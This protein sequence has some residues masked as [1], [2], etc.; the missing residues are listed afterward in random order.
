MT[1]DLHRRAEEL[2]TQAIHTQTGFT[3]R[4]FNTDVTQEEFDSELERLNV[5][6]VLENQALQQENRQLSVLLK[7]YEGTL[8]TV[9]GKFR[10]HAYATQ[11]HHLDLVRHYESILLALP[12]STTDSPDSPTGATIDPL[13]LS[14]SLA[15]LASLIRK[16]L[17]SIQGED[18]DDTTSPLIF[19]SSSSS[20]Q[21]SSSDPQSQSSP[22]DALSS[23]SAAFLPPPLVARP[24]PRDESSGGYIGRSATTAPHHIPTTSTSSLVSSPPKPGAI[25]LPREEAQEIKRKEQGLGPVDEALEREIELEQQDSGQSQYPLS[26]SPLSSTRSPPPQTHSPYPPQAPA[27]PSEPSFQ[28]YSSQNHGSYAP[29]DLDMDENA[30]LSANAAPLSGFPMQQQQEFYPSQDNPV[31][32]FMRQDPYGGGR[33]GMLPRHSSVTSQQSEAD[34]GRRAGAV[35]RGVTRKVKLTKGNFIANYA[36]PPAIV[37]SQ[38][39]KYKDGS[40]RSGHPEEFTHLRYTAATVDPNYFVPSSGW[41]LRQTLW[42]RETE[43]L[44]AITSYNEDKNL[45][46]RTLHSVMT[47]VRLPVDF[48]LGAILT[49]PVSQVRDIVKSKSKFW[50]RGTEEGKGGWEKIVVVLVADGIDPCAKDTLDLLA[51]V[52]VYQDNIMKKAIDGKDT[53]AHIFEYTTQLS[54]DTTPSLIVPMAN[55]EKH[56]MVP[57]QFVFCLKQKNAK[58]INS[59]RWVFNAFAS[60]LNPEVCILIDAGTKPGKLSLYELWNTFYNNKNCGG[61]CG[62]IY[63]MLEGGKKLLNPLV[64]AQN[65]EYKMSTDALPSVSSGGKGEK[66]GVVE[67]VQKSA[68]DLDAAFKETVRKALTPTVTVEAYEK[69]SQEDENKNGLNTTTEQQQKK[70]NFYFKIILWTTAGLSL[71]RFIGCVWF[72][73]MMMIGRCFRKT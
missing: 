60:Q 13:H 37:N 46:S 6:L 54:V 26:Q 65:F 35:K 55:N 30:P 57:V 18:P 14:L 64:A 2:K 38:E 20:S 50:R 15:H 25:P 51:T 61:A 31:P 49:S 34:W 16:A 41:N 58:K 10:A 33:P 29:I 27:F 59:H 42:G 23:L 63:C 7:D 21:S 1:E 8:E 40:A 67:E 56:N 44:I 19:P 17:R 68:A 53:V 24:P 43:L 32:G 73:V 36:V 62:E 52:G 22:L 9:M 69:P 28:S 70:S 11:Q 48:W 3:L 45:Y 66:D 47:N 12:S 39:G 5:S 4:R 71:I 72:W